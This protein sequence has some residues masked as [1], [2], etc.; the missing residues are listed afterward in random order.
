MGARHR[1]EVLNPLVT[2]LEAELLPKL[3]DSVVRIVGGRNSESRPDR[4]PD[5]RLPGRDALPGHGGESAL[6]STSSP[7]QDPRIPRSLD[8]HAAALA[9]AGYRRCPLRF[10]S[11][12]MT[13]PQSVCIHH[14]PGPGARQSYFAVCRLGLAGT[15]IRSARRLPQPASTA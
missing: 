12:V 8:G 10:R 7:G 14:H 13:S 15:N 9:V 4:F 2:V 11:S 1:R 5:G 3:A 6:L